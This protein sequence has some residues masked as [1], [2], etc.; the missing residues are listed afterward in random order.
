P[1]AAGAIMTTELVRLAPT[2][3]VGESLKHIRAVAREKESIY[4][5]YVLQPQTGQLL[6]SVSLR[7]LVMAELQPPVEKGMRRKPLTGNPLDDQEAVAAKIAKYNLLAVPVLEKDG[8]VVGFVTVDDVIDVMI[9]EGTE[10]ALG[11]GA[12][13]A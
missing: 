4:A 9:E 8:S 7:D 11:M 12:I 3:S 10:D 6:G 5:C 1:P 2:W 13:E